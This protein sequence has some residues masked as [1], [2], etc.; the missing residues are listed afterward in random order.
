MDITWHADSS[1]FDIRDNFVTKEN[2][3]SCGPENGFTLP[4]DSPPW[5]MGYR[6]HPFDKVGLQNNEKRR[7]MGL[8][9]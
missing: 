4:V 5:K 9:R 6:S 1:L 2:D 3:Q 8:N 7:S